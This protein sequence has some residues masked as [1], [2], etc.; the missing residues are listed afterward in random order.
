LGVYVREWNLLTLE[1]AVRKM[2]SLSAAKLG[3][4]DRGTIRAGAY[5]DLCLFDP[6]TVIDRSTYADPFHYPDG[7]A[8]VM[9]NGKLTLDKG[10]PTGEKPGR[11]LRHLLP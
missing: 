5:A 3:L 8:Y 10:R 7:I 1:D 2:T 11:A 6:E 9:V 4:T